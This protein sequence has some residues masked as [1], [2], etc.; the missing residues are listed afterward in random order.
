[1]QE[2]TCIYNLNAIVETTIY[3]HNSNQSQILKPLLFFFLVLLADLS[4]TS[5]WDFGPA[6][7]I[8]F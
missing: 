6:G 3:V 2:D 4:E 7:A 8:Q 5:F 1:M